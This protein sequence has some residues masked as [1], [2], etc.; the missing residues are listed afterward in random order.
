MLG[1]MLIL[2]IL[3]GLL[4]IG[5]VILAVVLTYRSPNKP[6]RQVQAT[7]P[8]PPAFKWPDDEKSLVRQRVLAVLLA[9]LITGGLLLILVGGISK[10][11]FGFFAVMLY[12]IVLSAVVPVIVRLLRWGFRRPSESAEPIPGVA[13]LL[14][15]RPAARGWRG[16]WWLVA[17]AVAAAGGWAAVWYGLLPAPRSEFVIF[18]GAALLMLAVLVDVVRARN[19]A[20]RPGE[21]RQWSFLTPFTELATGRMIATLAFIG[22]IMA[23]VIVVP[24]RAAA[25][26]RDPHP[27][28][29]FLAALSAAIY[30]L[31]AALL[32]RVAFLS[33]APRLGGSRPEPP[34]LPALG[35]GPPGPRNLGWVIGL[36]IAVAVVLGVFITSANG[37]RFGGQ[38]VDILLV[39]GMVAFGAVMLVRVFRQTAPAEAPAVAARVAEAPV[40]PLIATPAPPR[41]C[42]KCGAPIAAGAPE[43]LCPRC[44]IGGL[45]PEEPRH[46]PTTAYGPFVPPA[47]EEVAPF[48]PQLE[49]IRLIGQ[50]GMGAVYLA[51]QKQL[52][53]LVALKLINVREDDPTF[54]ERF[55]R[56]AKAMGKLSHPNIVTIHDHGTADGLPYLVME[57]VD[58]VTLR[59]AMRAKT[60]SPAEVLK[61]IPQVCDAL[62]YAHAQGVVHR[63]VKPENIL[64]DRSGKVKIADFGLAKLM[65]PDG[66]SLTHTRQAMGTPHYMAPE[67]WERP[68]EVDHRA[69]IYS[70]GVLLYELL[71]GELPLGRFDPP[72]VKARVDARIDELVLRALAKE[73]ARRYQHAS[74]M[75]LALANLETA[76]GW[77]RTATYREYKSK[78]TFAGWPLVH[79][80]AGRDPVTGQPKVAKGW[81]AVGEG[82]AVGGLAI[83]GGAAVGGIAVAGGFSAGL[84]AVSGGMAIGVL[85]LAGGAGIG[86]LAAVGGVAVSAGLAVGGGAVGRFAIGG[87]AF[88]EHVI[89]GQRQDADFGQRLAEWV[90][91]LWTDYLW[92][93]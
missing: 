41:A 76:G 24:E 83:S 74:D 86:L 28:A 17:L 63:D 47:V 16:H 5:G 66:L 78:R 29:L 44:L 49:I 61:V 67:Q 55:A 92:P 34:A 19:W 77:I 22:L 31:S 85:A 93:V 68:T 15:P 9:L 45:L 3:F 35:A 26:W 30:L 27:Q 38:R 25:L 65:D 62:E 60:L 2:G 91:M 42:P 10:A 84:L 88:G 4:V 69:D 57:Y 40:V 87:A 13:Q 53:R 33:R 50:G 90:Q 71:T 18:A 32:V 43:G 80:V 79:V 64:L 46:S 20:R 39:G 12:V 54:A 75:K 56:E 36:S 89:G 73:P 51:R 14:T 1:L 70:L 48:F 7:P 52:D 37:G 6:R 81:I 23:G 72:S 11:G 58:G 21:P 59:D 82:A 8:P